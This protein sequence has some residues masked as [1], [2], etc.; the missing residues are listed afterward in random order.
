M[1]KD[2]KAVMARITGTVQGVS[3]RVWARLEARSSVSP[4]GS[5]TKTTGR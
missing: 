3:F 1:E 5:A 2:R 4:D